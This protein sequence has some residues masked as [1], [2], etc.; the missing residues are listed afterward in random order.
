M[1]KYVRPNSRQN[2]KQLAAYLE[3]DLVERMKTYAKRQ[4][5]SLTEMIAMSVN[6]AVA[7]HGM[8]PILQVS[9]ERLVNRVRSPSMVQTKGPICRAGTKR[10]AAFYNNGDID[11]LRA[12][13]KEK[14]IALE[15]IVDTGARIVLSEPPMANAA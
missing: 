1:M 15:D 11:R 10:I 12:F 9:R 13:S 5:L 6:A 14:G 4:S 7:E 8:G 2:K 3:A